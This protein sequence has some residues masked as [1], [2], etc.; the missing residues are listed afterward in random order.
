MTYKPFNSNDR[1]TLFKYILE[2]NVPDKKKSKILAHL[3][4]EFRQTHVMY[5]DI[6]DF[7]SG[8]K[9]E[10]LHWYLN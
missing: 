2:L 9:E 8:I 10:D 7:I 1:V 3:Y 4:E 5:E 6:N